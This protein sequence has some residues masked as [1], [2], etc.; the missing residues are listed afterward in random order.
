MKG[1]ENRP[2]VTGIFVNQGIVSAAKRVNFV[3]ARMSYIVLRGCWCN[4]IVLN[5]HAPT[6]EKS[7]DSKHRF[8]EELEQLFDHFPKHMKILLGI[9]IQSSGERIFSNRKLRVGV[10]VRIV[11]IMV[12][13]SRINK[14][15]FKSSLFPHRNI[16]TYTWT[17]PDGKTHNQ[18]DHILIDRRRHSSLLD[19]DL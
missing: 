14:L 9:L 6:E 17:S 12:L 16:H 4:I 8:Y 13:E 2:V 7:D 3:S 5:A 18:I 15:I 19:V 10:Y 11:M 1:N